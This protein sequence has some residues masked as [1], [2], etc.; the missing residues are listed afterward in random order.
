MKGP[1]A[2][3]KIF[4]FARKSGGRYDIP[5]RIHGSEVMITLDVISSDIPLLLSKSECNGNHGNN[6]GSKEQ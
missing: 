5:E 3:N 2:L 4:S 6:T 1:E